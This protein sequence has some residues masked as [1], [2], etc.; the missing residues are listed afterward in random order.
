MRHDTG[1]WLRRAGWFML[2]W[3]VG[4]L[5]LGAVAAILRAAMR[6]AGLST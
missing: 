2:F 4:V 5:A 3:C 6:A 1:A